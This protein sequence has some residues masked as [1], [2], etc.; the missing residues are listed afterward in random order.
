M[1]AHISWYT[2]QLQAAAVDIFDRERRPLPAGRAAAATSSTRP[3]ATSA[4]RGRRRHR[5]RLP[6][7]RS[8][9]ARRGLHRPGAWWAATPTARARRAERLGIP[10]ACTSL[11]AALEL[12]GV[13]AVT[14]A[15]PPDTHARARD[16]SVRGRSSR[17]MREAV[18]ARCGRGRADARRRAARGVTHLVGHEFRWAP[19]RALVARAIADGVI[20]EPR[21]VLARLVRPARRRPG[22][23]RSRVVV[24]RS[25]RWRLARRVGLAHR[26]PAAHLGRGDRVGQRRAPDR[27]CARRRRGGQFRRALHDAWRRARGCIQQTA[28]SWVPERRRH[29]RSSPGPKAR[30]RSPATGVFCSDRSGRRELAVPADLALPAPPDESGDPRE[31]YTHLELGPYTRLAEALRDGRRGRDGR[32]LR[33][34]SRPSPTVWPRCRCSTR[35]GLRPPAAVQS[36]ASAGGVGKD[37]TMHVLIATDGSPSSIDA[38]R[39]A[40]RHPAGPPITSRC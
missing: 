36:S 4:G 31:R 9:A 37:H 19:D 16:R 8:R 18:R 32:P 3:R 13:D 26:R 15:T 14:I 25:A 6:R 11:A 29:H 10:H 38:A 24:R 30:S 17:R 22:R 20:G 35:S 39:A 33:F 12:D 21:T 2:P 23:A 1:T 27:E 40:A 7:S 28:A 5:L 34:R